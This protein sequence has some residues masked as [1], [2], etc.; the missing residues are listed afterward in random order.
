M[1]LKGT[2]MA[3]GVKHALNEHWQVSKYRL[4]LERGLFAYVIIEY[5]DTTT[6]CPILF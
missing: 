2:Q 6:L 1:N 5:Y 4:E 3:V